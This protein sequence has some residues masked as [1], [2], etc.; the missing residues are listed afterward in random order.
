MEYCGGVKNV[1]IAVAEV[2]NE[3]TK[4][5]ANAISEINAIRSVIYSQQGMTIR[6]ASNIGIGR[7][8]PYSGLQADLNMKLTEAF[9]SS[10][11]PSDAQKHGE[12]RD[13]QMTSFYFCS[14]ESCVLTFNSEDELTSHISS[15]SHL[16][17]DDRLNVYDRAKVQL[18][19]KLRDT[20]A[21]TSRNVDTL[22][23]ADTT[24]S[25]PSQSLFLRS[26]KTRGIFNTEGWALKVQKPRRSSDPLIKA[27]IK[28]VIEEEKLYGTKFLEKEY[29]RR[30]RTS[31]NDDGSKMF[32]TDQYLTASQV[33]GLS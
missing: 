13:R 9:T 33:S 29:V 22:S 4:I 27:F 19:D 7:T 26:A 23:S 16:T 12:R 32:Q 31:R 14:Q 5:K 20:R 8:I 10:N 11:V 17:I 1:R 24:A 3:Q 21:S 6:K 25:V 2:I 18:F 15:G 28:S 30:I